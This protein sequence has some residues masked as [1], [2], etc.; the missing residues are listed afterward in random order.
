[1]PAEAVDF[2]EIHKTYEPKIHAYLVRLVGEDQVDDLTQEVFM[3]IS[4]ALADFRGESSLSTWIYKIATNAALDLMRRQAFKPGEPLSLED[5]LEAETGAN[6]ED[7]NPWTGE[8][9]LLPEK[10]VIR[11]FMDDCISG[12]IQQLPENYRTVLVLSEYE[13]LSNKEIAAVLDLSVDTVKIRLHRARAKLK[14]YLLDNCEYYW[15]DELP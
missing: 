9:P 14:E 15:S 2:E 1:M 8:K 5:D 4:R 13:R 7:R 6:L 3:R 12:Y 10:Q 11:Q